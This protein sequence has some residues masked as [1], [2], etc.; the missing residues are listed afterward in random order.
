MSAV[1]KIESQMDLAL[2][3]ILGSGVDGRGG[4][5]GGRA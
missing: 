1:A 2:Q 4:R 5:G 3:G